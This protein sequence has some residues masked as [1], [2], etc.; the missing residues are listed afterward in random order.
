MPPF[1]PDELVLR[2]G[3][4]ATSGGD[5]LFLA[6]ETPEH[7]LAGFLRLSLPKGAA[8]HAELSG[9][10]LIRE[11]HVYGESLALGASGAT[12]HAGLGREL[13]AR[14]VELARDAG[15]ERL[16]VIAA[17]GT[18]PWYAA[19]GFD[20]ARLYPSRALFDAVL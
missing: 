9:A 3:R 16:A 14:A 1:D 13:V 8:P 19:Q 15:Y 12:Q 20:A 7:R 4:T 5:E 17:V 18:R 10:A 6:F 2:E 11:V